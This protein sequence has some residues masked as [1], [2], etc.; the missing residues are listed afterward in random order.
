VLE[1]AR[2]AHR[3]GASDAGTGPRDDS[4]FSGHSVSPS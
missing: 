4:D 1:I 2:E 3:S